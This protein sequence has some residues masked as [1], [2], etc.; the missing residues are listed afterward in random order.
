M[1]ESF[2]ED[3]W[4]FPQRALPFGLI[5]TQTPTALCNLTQLLGGKQ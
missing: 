2:P 4:K 1:P 5:A 3:E